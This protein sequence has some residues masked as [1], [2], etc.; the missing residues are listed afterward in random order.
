HVTGV[1]TCALPI[2]FGGLWELPRAP[3]AAGLVRMFAGPGARLELAGGPPILRHRQVLSHRR[4]V[5]DVHVG[6]LVGRPAAAAAG[7]YDRIAW[8][9][10][11]SLD[12]LGL[13]AASRAILT[14]LRENDGW[15][16]SSERS[17]SSRRATRRS[18]R[19]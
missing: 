18:S 11:D 2:F 3:D 16:Q 5:I 4:L 1:Q 19:A 6:R 7:P 9:G 13:A 14:K 8:H 17:R 12:S 15:T 10:L